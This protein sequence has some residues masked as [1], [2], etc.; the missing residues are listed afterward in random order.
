MYSSF[1]YMLQRESLVFCFRY[2]NFSHTST[3]VSI[4]RWEHGKN[5]L[6]FLYIKCIDSNYIH[7]N[8]NF[9]FYTHV[10]N[11]LKIQPF[12]QKLKFN[13]VVN[14]ETKFIFHVFSCI[15]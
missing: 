9:S 12:S 6:Y 1:K 2:S 4:T 13:R 5:V 3:S 11:N 7:S 8:I 15:L 14:F 10:K